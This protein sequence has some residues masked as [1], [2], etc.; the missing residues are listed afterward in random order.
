MKK[1][2]ILFVLFS[3][4]I[5][6]PAYADLNIE[7]II[8]ADKGDINTV[9]ALLN[10]GADVNAKNRQGR[11]ALIA[12]AE[13]G[14]TNTVKLLLENGADVNAKDIY[15]ETALIRAAKKGHTKIIELL[16][17]HGAKEQDQLLSGGFVKGRNVLE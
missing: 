2:W 10:I 15:G 5:A 7:L 9:R 14:H 3:L 17:K 12:A 4:L 6:L 8:A 1:T 11:T 13:S 16:K